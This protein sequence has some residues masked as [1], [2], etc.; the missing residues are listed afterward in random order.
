[1][2][3]KAWILTQCPVLHTYINMH[4]FLVW[5]FVTF[6]HMH[7]IASCKCGCICVYWGWGGMGVCTP[8]SICSKLPAQLRCQ[9]PYE[10]LSYRMTRR[11]CKEVISHVWNVMWHAMRV[12]R[13]IHTNEFCHTYEWVTW[14][15]RMSYVTHMNESYHTYEWVMS[16]IWMSNVCFAHS[17]MPRDL[18]IRMTQLISM[19]DMTHSYV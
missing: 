3:Q 4:S 19:C 2:V 8:R 16:H 11:A 9:M 14:N 1:M 10:P 12:S 6:I 15:K 13:F 17:C 7:H 18:V 5:L